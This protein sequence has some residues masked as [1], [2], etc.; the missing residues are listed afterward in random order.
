MEHWIG[1]FHTP[2]NFLTVENNSDAAWSKATSQVSLNAFE[3]IL[4]DASKLFMLLPK[5]SYFNHSCNPNASNL[6]SKTLTSSV[7]YSI[8]DI[9]EVYLTNIKLKETNRTQGEEVTICYAPATLV[10]PTSV[11]KQR[12]SESYGFSCDCSRCS[13]PKYDELLLAGV[14]EEIQLKFEA[15]Q[16]RYELYVKQPF[17]TTCKEAAKKFED[18]TVQNMLPEMNWMNIAARKCLVDTHLAARAYFEDLKQVKSV[19]EIKKKLVQV[20]IL[21]IKTNE[22]FLPQ[23]H[24]EKLIDFKTLEELD[25]SAIPTPYL[26]IYNELQ[27]MF[28]DE[29]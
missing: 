27:R 29:L 9:K 20:L 28:R 4:P 10:L 1:H 8:A 11:R 5:V 3:S 24:N 14:T 6:R 2:N 19:K 18:F 16:E 17:P 25:K 23:Y 22:Q 13:D 26:S 7:V 12:L 21:Q 15:C